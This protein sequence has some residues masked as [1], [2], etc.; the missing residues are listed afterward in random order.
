[1]IGFPETK[2]RIAFYNLPI[3]DMHLHECAKHIENPIFHGVIFVKDQDRVSEL[4]EKSKD[5]YLALG[6]RLKKSNCARWIF[7]SKA[8]V[9]F[10]HLQHDR[11][12][13]KWGGAQS[14]LIIFDDLTQFS[15]KEFTYM[16]TR[17]RVS[18]GI[19]P[20]VRATFGKLNQDSWVK[21]LVEL[22]DCNGYGALKYFSRTDGKFLLFNC[23]RK[24]KEHINRVYGKGTFNSEWLHNTFTCFG[25]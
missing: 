1:M 21:E 13:Y 12:L 9:T 20:Y 16:L 5:I 10:A 17:N 19:K 3:G 15:N 4:V 18:G 6:G 25:D 11:D 23:E 2:A 22:L 7:P 24:F 14:P 8:R